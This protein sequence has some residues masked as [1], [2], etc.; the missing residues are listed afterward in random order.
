MKFIH[1]ADLH[2]GNKMHDIERDEE[3]VNFFGWL[4]DT[5]VA[6]QADTLIIAGDVY[7]TVNPP[8]SAKKMFTQFLAS[9]IPTDCKNIVVIAGNHDSGAYLDADNDLLEMLNIHVVGSIANREMSDL[10]IKLYDKDKKLVGICVA[11][12]YVKESELRRFCDEDTEDK[13]FGDKAFKIIYSQALEEAKK[14][15]GDLDIPIITTGHLYAANLE[16][17]YEGAEEHERTDDG[18]RVIDVVGNLG[19]IHVG[20]FPG[21]Y[22]YVALGHIHYPSRVAENNK[23][24]YSG[25]PFIMGFDET[26]ITH[27]VLSI[28]CEKGKTTYFNKIAVPQTYLFRRFTGNCESLKNQLD[29]LLTVTKD[30]EKVYVE[31][32]YPA[33]ES[34]DVNRMIDTYEFPEN[35]KV[36]STKVVK[37][38]T[39]S[40]INLA[41]RTMREMKEIDPNEIFESLL[42]SNISILRGA[43]SSSNDINNGSVIEVANV[44]DANSLDSN[45]D[46]SE[47]TNENT[48]DDNSNSSSDE[49]SEEDK[50]LVNSYLKLF[51]EAF[52]EVQNG[53]ITNENN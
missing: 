8:I 5:I 44:T 21:E 41:K 16:G 14:V 46:S 4:K 28:A 10:V 36:V 32:C 2:L 25:S 20:A 9:L 13:S 42:K 50:E 47:N 37:T 38:E 33:I 40:S 53:G 45:D 18:V 43:S 39:N 22:D 15:R 7:D 27:C 34:S 49:L 12:P 6:E 17:R 52:Q 24:R 26:D 29:E 23:I 51:M 30:S 35:I 11:V 1:T 48:S 3:Y 19:S 31:V